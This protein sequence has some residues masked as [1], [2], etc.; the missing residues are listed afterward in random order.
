MKER[1]ISFNT[2]MVQAILDQRKNQTRRVIKPQPE[3]QHFVE[4][5]LREGPGSVDAKELTK[6]DMEIDGLLSNCPYGQPGDLLYV[7]ETCLL[8]RDFEGEKGPDA[9][10]P[11]YSTD[12]DYEDCKR[13]MKT[14]DRKNSN[15][16]V[17]SPRF[18]PKWAS[19]IWLEVIDVR[20]ER[21]QD[22]MTEAIK[23]EGVQI[24]VHNGSPLLPIT[25]KH[26]PHKYL[27]KA[28]KEDG[29][30]DQELFMAFWVQLWDSIN[31]KRGFGWDENPWVWV[32]VFE[33]VS[34]NGRPE[35]QTE[36]G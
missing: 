32:V 2:E 16:V 15:W 36:V 24:P 4:T 25:D 28:I 1:P 5:F 20:V 7:R 18:M 12:E 31:A 21:V 27:K 13:D 17:T 29:L 14:L 35:N 22:I 9:E 34:T 19:R 8:W 23:S 3:F 26:F 6:A 10:G 33:V 30:T 11:V